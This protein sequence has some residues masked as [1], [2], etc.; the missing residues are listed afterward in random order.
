MTPE[1][2]HQ[3]GRH[4]QLL[5]HDIFYVEQGSSAQ[6]TVLLIHGFPT[7]GWDWHGVMS[8]LAQY[9]VLVPDM[10]GYGFSSKPWPHDYTTAEQADLIEALLEHKNIGECH[11]LAHDYG[12]TVAQELLAR[13]NARDGA[14]RL[15]S[16]ALLNG[17]LFPEATRPRL[18]QKLML[19]PL[20]PLMVK[21]VSRRTLR[22]NMHAIFGLRTPP[23][24]EQIDA[25]WYL[26]QFNQGRRVFHRLIQYIRER[27]IYRERWLSALRDTTV[28]RLLINGSVDPISGAHL[29]AR[30]GELIDPDEVI[31][32]SNI[33]HYPQVEAPLEVVDHYLRFVREA[34]ARS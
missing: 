23:T 7:A 5:G 8:G 24:E 19:G 1:T 13:D 12:D 33:G 21:L 31:S 15:R 18:I 11:V 2:W 4:A 20:G 22:R 28:P 16:V 26:I 30:Y 17:G 34:Q 29:A 14:Q 9:H 3:A 27:D 6:P 25:F 32:L 10:L